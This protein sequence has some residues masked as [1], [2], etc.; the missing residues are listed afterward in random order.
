MPTPSAP[1]AALNRTMRAVGF[2]LSL[3]AVLLL[4]ADVGGSAFLYA[5]LSIGVA[6]FGLSWTRQTA[7]APQPVRVRARRR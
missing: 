2:V 6:T 5:C 3:A 1:D 4:A 7:P